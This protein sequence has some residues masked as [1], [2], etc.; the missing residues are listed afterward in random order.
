MNLLSPLIQGTLLSFPSLGI[1][2]A[3]GEVK[4][5]CYVLAQPR[6]SLEVTSE[7]GV[8]AAPGAKNRACLLPKYVAK[9]Y[10]SCQAA[11]IQT[12]ESSAVDFYAKIMKLWRSSFSTTIHHAS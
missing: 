6:N 4:H 9:V 7:V 11:D 5:S 2:L 12:S 10:A 3:A 1:A 8:V